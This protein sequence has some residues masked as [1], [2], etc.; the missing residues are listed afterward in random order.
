VLDEITHLM[1]PANPARS[2][3][4]GLAPDFVDGIA[5]VCDRASTDRALRVVGAS[6]LSGSSA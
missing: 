2:Q 3:R 6:P 5:G 1:V 4:D